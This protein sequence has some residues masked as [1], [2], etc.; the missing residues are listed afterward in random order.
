MN[1]TANGRPQ[2]VLGQVCRE[3]VCCRAT[4][5]PWLLDLM[6]VSG[7]IVTV[8]APCAG[9]DIV[10]AI[11]GRGA[12]YAVALRP[13]YG[14]IFDLAEV[15]FRESEPISIFNET[16]DRRS[17]LPRTRRWEY[18]RSG[19]EFLTEAGWEGVRGLGMV[20]T[21]IEAPDGPRI[22]HRYY[23]SSLNGGARGFYAAV[24]THSRVA[25]GTLWTVTVT[26]PNAESMANV[27]GT[28]AILKE[29]LSDAA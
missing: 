27:A 22:Q 7:C 2:L 16:T 15:G 6:D 1:R 26:F 9:P 23:A 28:F 19:L 29:G 5:V 24:E 11:L 18:R 12:D 4:A 8:D 3:N 25:E 20:E 14:P 10:R 17:E 13:E 21:E